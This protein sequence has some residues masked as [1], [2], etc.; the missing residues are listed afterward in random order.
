MKRQE[1]SM[2][3]ASPKPGIGDVIDKWL[4]GCMLDWGDIALLLFL[5]LATSS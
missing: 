5:A 2:K 1:I 4:H 3:S